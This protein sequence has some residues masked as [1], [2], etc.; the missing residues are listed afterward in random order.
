LFASLISPIFE[1]CPG[2]AS[3][4]QLNA[5][6]AHE[7]ESNQKLRAP[8]WGRELDETDPSPE[9]AEIFSLEVLGQLL[10]EI[11]EVNGTILAGLVTVGAYYLDPARLNSIHLAFQCEPAVATGEKAPHPFLTDRT[12]EADD[13]AR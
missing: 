7:V 5:A 4:G 1:R 11:P 10:L 2:A 12:V 6:F 13:P 9:I 3:V 8:A